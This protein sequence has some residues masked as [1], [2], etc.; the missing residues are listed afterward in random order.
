MKISI[1]GVPLVPNSA[2]EYF[3]RLHKVPQRRMA[4]LRSMRVFGIQLPPV[5]SSSWKEATGNKLELTAKTVQW[6][7]C[8]E[9]DFLWSSAKISSPFH[10]SPTTVITLGKVYDLL[11]Y[12]HFYFRSFF[13]FPS[14]F[15]FF[16]LLLFFL[17]YFLF[18][19]LSI[20]NFSSSGHW[21]RKGVRAAVQRFYRHTNSL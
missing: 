9:M 19:Y 4:H 13:F 3:H 18:I 10:Q 20:F 5:M 21:E 1:R 2:L 12:F 8:R 11:I 7:V 16:H 17:Y 14:F 15:F 6:P